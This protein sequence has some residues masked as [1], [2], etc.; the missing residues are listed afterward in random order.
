[1]MFSQVSIAGEM[2]GVEKARARVRELT[3]LLFNYPILSY[4]IL[5]CQAL[6]TC[7]KY[8]QFYLV[9]DYTK[10]MRSLTSQTPRPK[11][12]SLTT[13]EKHINFYLVRDF[14]KYEVYE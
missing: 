9:R 6:T 5:S 11:P 1:M 4:P 10:N 12:H 8:I 2:A 3:P 13:C 14:Q 7:E